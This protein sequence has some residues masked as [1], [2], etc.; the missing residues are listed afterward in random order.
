MNITLNSV[1]ICRVNSSDVSQETIG[2]ATGLGLVLT[3]A[4]NIQITVVGTA[5]TPNV[6]DYINVVF[7]YTNAAMTTQ[8]FQF[9]P[10][11]TINTPLR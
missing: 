8:S 9:T 11:Q 1:F 3:T 4:G 6:G 5:Q 10:N 7:V 2:S